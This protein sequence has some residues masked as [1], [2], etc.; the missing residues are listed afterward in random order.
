MNLSL[1]KRWTPPILDTPRLR[2]R[3]LERDDA[4]AVFAMCSN[5]QMTDFTLWETHVTLDDSLQFVRDYAS[6][7]Y[8]ERVPEPL[9][10]TWR[11]DPNQRII[12]TLGGFWVS[13]PNGTME[14]GYAI[15]APCWGMGLATEAS[16][17]LINYLF[18]QFPIER[19]Q[20]RSMAPN[21]ASIRVLEKLGFQFEG[22]QRSL[23]CRRG[24]YWDVS[25]FAILRPEW[26]ARR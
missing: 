16:S 22:T 11:N 21:Q 1:L 10:I 13:Q 5:P 15:A 24:A 25:I 12:G 3:G 18:E 23:I 6:A 2:I 17:A 4:E 19:L 20:A 26:Q 7:R 8:R 14:L 9:G